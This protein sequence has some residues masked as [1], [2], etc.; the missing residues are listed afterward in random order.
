VIAWIPPP[1]PIGLYDRS[2][3]DRSLSS[4]FHAC[5]IGSTRDE[6][7]PSSD[8][9]AFFDSSPLDP[10]HAETPA[11]SRTAPMRVRISRGIV[12]ER[13]PE[14]GRSTP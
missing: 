7:A 5:T 8:A 12:I 11:A 9:L 1:D 6:P 13:Y 3:P 4:G 14:P 10:P 2:I